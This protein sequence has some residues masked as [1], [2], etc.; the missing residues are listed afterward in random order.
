MTTNLL[1]GEIY[2]VVQFFLNPMKNVIFNLLGLSEIIAKLLNYQEGTP[3]NLQ[4]RDGQG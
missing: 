2:Y 3:Q 4:M 1:E